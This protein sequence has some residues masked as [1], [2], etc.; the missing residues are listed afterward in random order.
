MYLMLALQTRETAHNYSTRHSYLLSLSKCIKPIEF[1]AARMFS[2]LPPNIRPL[3]GNQFQY[4]VKNLLITHE[5]YSVH[6][7]WDVTW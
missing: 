5:F 3:N 2:K 1:M 6:E 4:D 7:V